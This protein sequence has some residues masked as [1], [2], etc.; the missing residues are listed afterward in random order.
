ML[1]MRIKCMNCGT[2][3][4][5]GTKFN[6]RKEQVTG[7]NYKLIKIFRFYFK[8]TVC[9]SEITVKTDPENSDYVVESGAVRC[10]EVCLRA[11]DDDVKELKSFEFEDQALGELKCL[12]SRRSNVSTDVLLECLKRSAGSVEQQ[13]VEEED[14]A[15]VK[16]VFGRSEGCLVRRVD[17]SLLRKRRKLI[18]D[19]RKPED[20]SVLKSS[21]VQFVVV[22]K[23]KLCEYDSD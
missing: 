7:E 19:D 4:H 20:S 22:S 3:L 15:L 23:I 2:Y 9:S 8:C 1:P 12:K 21:K 13:K 11:D 5:E 17:D 10:R 16:A 6:S 18:A 14:E